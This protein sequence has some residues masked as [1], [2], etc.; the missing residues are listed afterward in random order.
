MIDA[1]YSVIEERLKNVKR[2]IAIS[3]GKG[4]VGKSMVASTISLILAKKYKVG[5]LDLD[6]Y[7]PSSHIIINADKKPEEKNG[8]IPPEINGLKF[9]SIIYFTEDKPS[10][11][12]GKDII[13]AIVELLA[14]TIWGNLD[15]LIID[16][17]PGM[18]EEVMAIIKFMKR[19]EFV[20]VT[21]PSILA[22]ETVKKLL[23]FL[24]NNKCNILG[25]IENMVREESIKKEIE[26]SFPYMGS[27]KF[28]YDLEKYIGK[29]S[30]LLESKFGNEMEKI[31]SKHF[32]I[33][34]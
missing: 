10:P 31:V 8:L 16:M 30:K 21:T 14:I 33:A 27:I 6:F 20:V 22:W 17:P 3:S 1:R 26:K 32:L 12:K 2:I 18:G 4:G 19:A 29:P 5:L 13:N 25:I 28:D 24:K 15:F 23:I 7:G 34:P 11:L 9:M